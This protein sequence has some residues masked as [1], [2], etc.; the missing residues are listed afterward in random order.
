MFQAQ[1]PVSV[2]LDSEIRE[3]YLFLEGKNFRITGLWSVKREWD[4]RLEMALGSQL[5][6]SSVR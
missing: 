5:C 3:P 6:V 2:F 1:E 4:L